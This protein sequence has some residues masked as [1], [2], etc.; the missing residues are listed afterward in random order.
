MCS[1]TEG[2]AWKVNAFDRILSPALTPAIFIAI[3]MVE[4]QEFPP[5]ACLTPMNSANFFSK[6]AVIDSSFV[7]G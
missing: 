7:F 1:I 6:F 2:T 4:P 5:T 3:N